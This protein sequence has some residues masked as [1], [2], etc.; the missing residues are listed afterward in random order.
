M[1]SSVLLHCAKIV[2]NWPFIQAKKKICLMTAS[3]QS[4]K[5]VVVVVVIAII[6]I[7]IIIIAV[8]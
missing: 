3:R 5:E 2:A 7:I 6:I 1:L 4:A 8:K